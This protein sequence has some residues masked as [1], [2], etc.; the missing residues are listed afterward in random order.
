[1]E[2]NMEPTICSRVRGLTKVL[3]YCPSD[4]KLHGSWALQG[5]GFRV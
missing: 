1:M 3:S 2:K 4:G 5:L